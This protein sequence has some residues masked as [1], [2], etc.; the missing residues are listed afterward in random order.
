MSLKVA[1]LPNIA[2]PFLLEE[3]KDEDKERRKEAEAAPTF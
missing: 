2:L 1:Y 3:K